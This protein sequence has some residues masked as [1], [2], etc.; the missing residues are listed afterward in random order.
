MNRSIMIFYGDN[1]INDNNDKDYDYHDSDD[2]S[3]AK[4]WR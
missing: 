1:D 4:W 3:D 2:N